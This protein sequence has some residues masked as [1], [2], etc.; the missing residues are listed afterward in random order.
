MQTG[1]VDGAALCRLLIKAISTHGVP[2]RLS[3][4]NVPLFLYHQWRENLKIPGV[5]EIKTVPY[6]PLSHPFV[7][8]IIGTIRREL[9]DHTLFWNAADFQKKLTDFQT[10]YNHRLSHSSLM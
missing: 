3:A 4:E 8:Q 2:K 9:L 5:D 1:T 6:S 7:E 10:Y